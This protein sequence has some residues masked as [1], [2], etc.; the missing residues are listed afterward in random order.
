MDTSSTLYAHT[1]SEDG[2]Y[3]SVCQACLAGIASHHN[4][5]ALAREEQEHVCR[6]AVWSHQP[7]SRNKSMDG[8]IG[9]R[10]RTVHAGI[11]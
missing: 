5:A 11:W 7:G 8:P 1:R 9:M 4:E 2:N 3:H 6:F 10:S